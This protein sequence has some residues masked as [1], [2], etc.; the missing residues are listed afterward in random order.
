MKIRANLTLDPAAYTFASAYA[1]AKGMPLG[2]AISELILRA[3]Q[4]PE[5]RSARLQADEQ[6]LLVV[7]SDGE[8]I[9]A[10][11]VK[12]GSEDSL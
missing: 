9:T 3:E 8:A 11:M 12:A 5:P 10:E 4:A 7:E 1:S 6:G 2:N